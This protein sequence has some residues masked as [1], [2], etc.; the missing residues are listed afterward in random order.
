MMR[1]CR[2]LVGIKM[3]TKGMTVE[4]AVDMFDAALIADHPAVVTTHCR[5]SSI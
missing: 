4:Q 2:Y 5:P 3:Y 1:A